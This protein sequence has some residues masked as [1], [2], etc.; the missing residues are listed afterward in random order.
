[1][2]AAILNANNNVK[3][4]KIDSFEITH[5]YVLQNEEYIYTKS[6]KPTSFLHTE[7]RS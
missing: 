6:L 2:T 1:M 4:F 7:S 3:I 5:V